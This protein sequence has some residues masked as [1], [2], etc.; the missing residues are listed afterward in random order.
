[1]GSFA[2]LYT[3]V[4]QAPQVPVRDKL[5]ELY[6]WHRETLIGSR[7]LFVLKGRA[8]SRNA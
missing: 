4:H 2:A 8:H 3:I 7:F 6:L 5:I 1:M